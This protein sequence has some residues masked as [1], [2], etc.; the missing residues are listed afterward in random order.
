MLLVYIQ[1]VTPQYKTE[2]YL[3]WMTN[4]MSYV[5]YRTAPLPMTLRDHEC[6]LAILN[7]STSFHYEWGLVS[8]IVSQ[9]LVGLQ[10]DE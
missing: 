2:T 1:M 10:A 3:Q 7:I 4:R 8:K 9:W 5:L 6:H